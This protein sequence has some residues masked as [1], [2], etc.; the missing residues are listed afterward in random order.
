MKSNEKY[1]YA[2]LII[3]VVWSVVLLAIV[4][5]N[6]NLIVAK[7]LTRADNSSQ[8]QERMVQS[9]SDRT[10][11]T[12]SDYFDRQ[13][14]VDQ[15]I[16]D[17]EQ[18]IND[19]EKNLPSL[20]FGFWR[21]NKKF[22]FLAKLN[23]SVQCGV[24]P[25]I[26]DLHFHNIYWQDLNSSN[27]TFHLLNAYYDSRKAVK[28]GPV[29]RI[30]GMVDRV[31]PTVK[32][33][34]QL[35]FEGRYEPINVKT[36]SYK[37]MWRT[38]WGNDVDGLQHP[39]LITCPIPQQFNEVVPVSVSLVEKPCD[40]PRNNL[41]VIYNKPID[42][43]RKG[44]GVCVKGLEFLYDDVSAKLVEWVELILMLGADKIHM[45]ELEVH[46]NISKVLKY[47]EDKGKVE[48]TPLMLAGNLPNV[49]GFQQL[50]LV[51]KPMHKR[52]HEM[53]PLNDCLYKNMYR[54]EYIAVLDIDEVIMPTQSTDFSWSDLMKRLQEKITKVYSTFSARNV[55]FFGDKDIQKNS[56]IP[57]YM[58]MLHNMKRSTNYSEAF[59][60]AKSFHD[61]KNI[62]IVHNHLA[63]A[64]LDH[65]NCQTL[66]ISVEDAQLNHYK[67]GPSGTFRKSCEVFKNEQ[68][69]DFTIFKFQD[70]MIERTTKA[71]NDLK[72]FINP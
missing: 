11:T 14:L 53:I 48:V 56:D 33:F 9:T 37:Y 55:Y 70:K 52:Q 27:G 1:F 19:I 25:T 10:Y 57:S 18:R 41:K 16:V 50:Y 64:C 63:I 42:G 67:A 69:N 32:T 49:K 29:V 39:Y 45:Y 38:I 44:F 20:P 54:Y 43:K 12:V 71:L 47:Y 30:I 5:Y 65:E 51:Q 17:D 3:L 22:Q 13:L 34:C 66:P 21:R 68:I 61:P 40:V 62:L 26:F 8:K 28:D 60:H 23:N 35:W 6:N 24:Y 59:K 7:F 46:A 36:A 15:R 4:N 31:Q 58:H 72:F 2:T